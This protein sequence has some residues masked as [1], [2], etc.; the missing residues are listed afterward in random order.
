MSHEEADAPLPSAQDQRPRLLLVDDEP[1]TMFAI[2]DCF[3]LAGYEV[4][5]AA[6]LRDTEVLLERHV[7]EAVIADLHFSS[8]RSGE[9]LLVAERARHVNPG[10]CFVLL[11]DGE[12]GDSVDAARRHGVSL[13]QTKPVNL[14]ALSRFVAMAV[15]DTERGKAITKSREP[16][17]PSA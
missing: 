13:I 6:S 5:C 2:R 16:R 15:R 12:W 17:G 7:Y 1:H 11:T 14:V 8:K 4:D 3:A 9:G 10:T